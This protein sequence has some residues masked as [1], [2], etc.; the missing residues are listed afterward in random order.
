M[1]S[2]RGAGSMTAFAKG[3]VTRIRCGRESAVTP[4]AITGNVYEHDGRTVRVSSAGERPARKFKK[5]VKSMHRD[6]DREAV[7][8]E[9]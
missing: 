8:T 5:A 7:E 2:L 6:A 4:A 1:F 9:S 3:A